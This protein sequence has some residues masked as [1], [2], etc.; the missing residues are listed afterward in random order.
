MNTYHVFNVQFSTEIKLSEPQSLGLDALIM[1]YPHIADDK[2]AL[3][4]VIFVLYPQIAKEAMQMSDDEFL[5]YAEITFFGSSG[6][7]GQAD[8]TACRNVLGATVE[9]RIV[10]KC[11][12]DNK[13]RE[14]FIVALDNGDSLVIGFEKHE[15]CSM[16]VYEQATAEIL[17][18]LKVC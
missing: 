2:S 14:T 16:S 3:F 6:Q 17:N 7:S 8:L 15:Q 4:S 1:K 18:S 9:S 13:Y 11:F 5:E 12:P 10:E